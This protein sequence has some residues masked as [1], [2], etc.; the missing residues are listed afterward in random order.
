MDVSVA[1]STPKG[2]ITPIVFSAHIKGLVEISQD[3]KSLA[4][5]ARDGKL[6]PHE[7]Q[8]MKIFQLSLNVISVLC[9]LRNFEVDT[10]N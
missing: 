9:C 5:K 6:Q 7:F 8:V 4:A 3:V 1:V 2:L 10:S